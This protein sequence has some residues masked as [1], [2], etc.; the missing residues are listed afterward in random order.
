LYFIIIFVSLIGPHG[1]AFG[2]VGFASEQRKHPKT[3]AQKQSTRGRTTAEAKGIP[4]WI[5]FFGIAK[6]ERY[7]HLPFINTFISF[8][9]IRESHG[10]HL[11]REILFNL[12]HFHLSTGRFAINSP[13]LRPSY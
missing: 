5:L 1:E 10:A 9:I 12:D 2:V 7:Y 4:L 8:S 3:T 13:N 11:T 6:Q